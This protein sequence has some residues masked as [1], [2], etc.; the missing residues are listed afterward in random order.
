[1]QQNVLQSWNDDQ[2]PVVRKSRPLPTGEGVLDQG[3]FNTI[4][5]D[6]LFDNVNYASTLAGQTVLYRSLTQP[7]DDIEAINAKQAAVREIRDN[8]D[9]RSNIENIVAQAAESENRLYLLLFGEFWGGFGTAREHHQ[10]EGYGYKQ[11]R[12]GVNAVLNLVGAIHNSGVPQTP[13]LQSVF[14]KIGDF[15]NSN[16]YSLRVGQIGRA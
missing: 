15:A 13:Y 12:R 8:P 10:I 11:Y 5:V 1:M 6:E 4:E 7:L 16:D 14:N 3:A 9:V 2:W